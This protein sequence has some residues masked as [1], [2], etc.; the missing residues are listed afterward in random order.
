MASNNSNRKKLHL[1]VVKQMISLSTSGFGLVAALAWNNVI[2]EFVNDYV[3][4]Y[5]EVG[6]GLI[7][8]LIYAILVTVLAVT[9]TYQL[10]KL[11]D[12]LEK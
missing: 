6:S 12:K 4:K 8:L 1:A 3:K 5:L 9:V 11:S 10:G 2:Q 7:S